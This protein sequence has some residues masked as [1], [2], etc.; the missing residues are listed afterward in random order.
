MSDMEKERVNRYMREKDILIAELRATIEK[1]KQ[2]L[3]KRGRVET[4][5]Q[6]IYANCDMH[7][8][9]ITDLQN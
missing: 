2:E 8:Q 6:F 3:E 4:Q 7:K 1:L 5:G 9:T